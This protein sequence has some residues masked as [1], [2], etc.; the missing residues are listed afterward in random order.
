MEELRL[1]GVQDNGEYLVLS[2]QDEK[3]YRILIDDALRAATTRRKN[4]EVEESVKNKDQS[5]RAIQARLRAGEA[6]AAIAEDL[7]LELSTVERYEAPI[8]AERNYLI[9]QVQNKP[10]GTF[11]PSHGGYWAAFGDNQVT[12]GSLVNYE[13]SQQNIDPENATWD[14]WKD[15]EGWKIQLGFTLDKDQDAATETDGV[16]TK[17]VHNALWSYDQTHKRLLPLNSLGEDLATLST[18]GDSPIRAH[19]D[20]V[21]DVNTSDPVVEDDTSV[22]GNNAEEPSSENSS[23]IET[24]K[25]L[26]QN[27]SSDEAQTL[28][29]TE[30]EN[31]TVEIPSSSGEGITNR[32]SI[33]KKYPNLFGA[34]DDETFTASNNTTMEIVNVISEDRNESKTDDNKVVN[35]SDFN[36][37][38]VVPVGSSIKSTDSS[39]A[40]DKDEKK[41]KKKKRTRIPSWDDIVF[42]PKDSN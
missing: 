31:A 22:L 10:L 8:S 32:H 27:Q 6:P 12:L 20:L 2:G 4:E 23:L 26:G 19:G 37:P 21:F 36:K 3:Q 28:G 5:P 7:E 33:A 15:N 11:S 1:N 9:E 18:D 17:Q 35:M 13:F 14:A 29:A 24:I 39:S 25:N 41:D 30:Q 16:A 42:G 40:K 34:K 38:K